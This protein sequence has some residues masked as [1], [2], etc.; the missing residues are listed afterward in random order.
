MKINYNKEKE[1][2]SL[3]GE[4]LSTDDCRDILAVGTVSEKE[5]VKNLFLADNNL[6]SLPFDPSDFPELLWLTLSTFIAS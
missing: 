2:L 4:G 5:N 3:M 1:S 6:S